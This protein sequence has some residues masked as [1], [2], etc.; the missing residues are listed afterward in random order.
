[1]FIALVPEF[2][3]EPLKILFNKIKKCGGGGVQVYFF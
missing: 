2:D 3:N 1:M